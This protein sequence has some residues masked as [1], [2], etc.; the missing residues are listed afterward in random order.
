MIHRMTT[1][2]FYRWSEV[3]D[4]RIVDGPSHT[5]IRIAWNLTV[6]S[7]HRTALIIGA[8]AVLGHH[9]SLLDTFALPADE[10]V[11]LLNAWQ[12][13]YAKDLTETNRSAVDT[14]IDDNGHFEGG[15][16]SDS[17]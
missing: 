3:Y 2:Q 8:H 1:E 15:R 10:L 13:Q 14:L 7:P 11:A 16:T 6:D 4:F 12:Q 5:G 9:A 17:T